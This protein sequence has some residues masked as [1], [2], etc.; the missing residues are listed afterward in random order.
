MAPREAGGRREYG[1]R[2]SDGEGRRDRIATP[3]ENEI[4]RSKLADDVPR[5]CAKRRAT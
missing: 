1:V 5:K 4:A 3:I 2:Y